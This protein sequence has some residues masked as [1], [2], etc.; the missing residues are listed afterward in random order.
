MEV[1]TK[2]YLSF[3]VYKRENML[4]PSKKM[5]ALKLFSNFLSQKHFYYIVEIIGYWE[6]YLR[7]K[8]YSIRIDEVVSYRVKMFTCFRAIY[9]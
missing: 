6:N 5:R 8:V 9:L 2:M 4:F 7:S 3:N 1:F